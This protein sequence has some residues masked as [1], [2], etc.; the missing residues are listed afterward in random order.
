MAHLVLINPL[1]G[2]ATGIAWPVWGRDH[3]YSHFCKTTG[4]S[5]RAVVSVISLVVSKHLCTLRENK[6]HT[7]QTSPKAYRARGW[8]GV[9]VTILEICIPANGGQCVTVSCFMTLGNLSNSLKG[10]GQTNT[11]FIMSL[12]CPIRKFV[13][14]LLHASIRSRTSYWHDPCNEHNI[15]KSFLP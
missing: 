9:M 12:K 15:K 10:H 4:K 13:I 8:W 1:C 5:L 7:K 3:W 11:I 2:F 6:V 14:P